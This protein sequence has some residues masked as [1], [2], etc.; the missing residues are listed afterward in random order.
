MNVHWTFGFYKIRQKLFVYKEVLFLGLWDRIVQSVQQLATGWTVWGSNHGGGEIF[1]THP[2]RPWG[3]TIFLY[4]GYRNTLG[5]K[6]PE[7]GIDHPPTSSVEI[8]EREVPHLYP[9]LGLRGLFQGEFYLYLYLLSVVALFRSEIFCSR[10][11]KH[12]AQ[13]AG[14]LVCGIM[15]A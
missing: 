4:N 2:G 8:K 3:L 10:H 1:C 14:Y 7:R 13:H 11:L 5:V 15:G 9:L 12:L 6:R